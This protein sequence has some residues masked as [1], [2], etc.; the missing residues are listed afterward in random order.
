MAIAHPGFSRSVNP[1]SMPWQL[2][3]EK[4]TKNE[5]TADKKIENIDERRTKLLNTLLD[6][7]IDNETYK[8]NNK[9]LIK[10]KNLAIQ[11]LENLKSHKNELKEYV[12][13]GAHMLENIKALYNRMDIR[14]KNKLLSSI[15]NEKLVFLN[16]NQGNRVQL[17]G[18]PHTLEPITLGVS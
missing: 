8:E 15:L 2:I 9:L 1:I 10:D 13:F 16:K 12:N 18:F 7:V 4:D 6:G 14:L 5:I 17:L 3:D 11:G